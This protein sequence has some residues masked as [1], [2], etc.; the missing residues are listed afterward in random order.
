MLSDFTFCKGAEPGSHCPPDML[1][2]LF[3]LGPHGKMGLGM[4]SR[5]KEEKPDPVRLEIEQGERWE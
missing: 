2:S 1:D 4:E 3:P 5:G